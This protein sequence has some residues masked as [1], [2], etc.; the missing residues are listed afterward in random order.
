MNI[1]FLTDPAVAL[2]RLLELYTT[3]CK[4]K[5]IFDKLNTPGGFADCR[6]RSSSER[7]SRS[8]GGSPRF[9]WSRSRLRCFPLCEGKKLDQGAAGSKLPGRSA[10]ITVVGS[11]LGE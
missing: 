1:F 5:D 2:E 3:R 8:R 10:K 11:R 9:L 7:K 4:V 6:Q